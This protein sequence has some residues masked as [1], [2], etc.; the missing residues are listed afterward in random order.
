ME[1]GV[2]ALLTLAGIGWSLWAKRRQPPAGQAGPPE[3]PPSALA[4]VLVG[5][6][7]L[8]GPM[9]TG[10]ALTGSGSGSGSASLS[11]ERVE[12]ITRVAVWG[13]ATAWTIKHPGTEPAFRASL[14]AI[15]ALVAEE[16]WDLTALAGTLT[17]TGVDTFTGDEARL[18]ISG[19]AL[20]LDTFGAGQVD[21]SRSEYVRAIILGSQA[22]LRLALG[23]K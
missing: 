7:L 5:C 10:C 22:G 15:D 3:T 12:R 4:P 11:P 20:A 1:Q 14:N 8:A 23:A 9:L 19:T 21:L 17:Q 6:A 13:T 16:R 18:I 2:G